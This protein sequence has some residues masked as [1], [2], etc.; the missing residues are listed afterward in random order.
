[1]EQGGRQG[2][3]EAYL[4]A[5]EGSSKSAGTR[6]RTRRVWGSKVSERLSRSGH[7]SERWRPW[8]GEWATGFSASGVDVG[9]GGRGRR[10]SRRGA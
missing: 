5:M 3:E 7:V 6:R 10:D 1:M 4:R 9:G 8:I 2:D